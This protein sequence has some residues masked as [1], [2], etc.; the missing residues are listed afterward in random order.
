MSESIQDYTED[1]VISGASRMI[2]P[3]LPPT[4]MADHEDVEMAYKKALDGDPFGGEGDELGFERLAKKPTQEIHIPDGTRFQGTS[5]A[6]HGSVA[7]EFEE[8]V[9]PNQIPGYSEMRQ[10]VTDV[11][12]PFLKDGSSF[13]DLGTSQGRSIRDSIGTLVAN[14][15]SRL[16]SVRF[17][18]YDIE[19]EMLTIAAA[20]INRMVMTETA[21]E[22]ISEL[23]IKSA[24]SAIDETLPN[25]LLKKEDLS[26]RNTFPRASVVTSIF[27][28]QF[29]PV[30]HRPRLLSEIYD[31]LE[32]GG[33]FVW[34]EKIMFPNYA[35]E[36]LMSTIY[37]DEKMKNGISQEDVVAKRKNLERAMIP[38]TH[39]MNMELLEGAGFKK[40]N[41]ATFW[42][43]LQFEA[44]LAVKE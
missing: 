25:V 26:T 37:Y 7:K 13:V 16:G 18:G 8:I 22:F 31:S 20:N 9:I 28:I 3:V 32:P 14:R 11:A 15:D 23:R 19:E 21:Q 1:E 40:R 35:V 12:L 33:A 24:I 4:S 17:Y 10:R 2:D 29:I 39:E 43:N 34:G 41:I 44:V 30:E 36:N 38:L 5:M 6:F 42:R 27:T